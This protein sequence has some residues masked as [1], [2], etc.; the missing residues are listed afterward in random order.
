L[1]APGG[2]VHKYVEHFVIERR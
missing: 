1:N 2:E